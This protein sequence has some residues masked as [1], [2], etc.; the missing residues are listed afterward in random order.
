MR[1]ILALAFFTLG[2]AC[3][4]PNESA[5]D[6]RQAAP[7]PITPPDPDDS[8]GG[9]GLHDEAADDSTGPELHG[10][11]SV[12]PGLGLGTIGMGGGGS[13]GLGGEPFD[14][15]DFVKALPEEAIA[16]NVPGKVPLGE[17]VRVRLRIEPGASDEQL[18]ADFEAGRTKR[19]VGDVATRRARVG[20]QM[21]ARLVSSSLEVTALGE[22]SKLVSAREPT[23]WLWD[24]KA[25]EGGTHTLRLTLSVIPP[26]RV[27]G[28]EILSLEEEMVVEVTALK[29]ALTV[30]SDN[31]EWM[32]TFIAAPLGGLWWARR[33]RAREQAGQAVAPPGEAAGKQAQESTGAPA[34]G[35][36]GTSDERGS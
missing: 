27:S 17:T 32:W 1:A 2:L 3:D 12:E 24:V 13:K 36:V 29:R 7:K 11:T 34:A 10:D 18:R 23:E 26:E 25:S 6:R 8:R 15:G 33:R 19:E 30:L 21:S 22:T 28:R 5:Q 9:G 20:D 31:W 35:A 4:A 16:F 14:V